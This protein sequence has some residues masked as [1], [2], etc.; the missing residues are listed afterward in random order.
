MVPV[1]GAIVSSPDTKVITEL[2]K[3]YPGRASISPILDLFITLLSMGENGL[4]ELWKERQ[5]LFI[6]LKEKLQVFAD[7][8][9]E[10][11]LISPANS[12]S[13]G[14]TLETLGRPK[15]GQKRKEIIEN[16]NSEQSSELQLNDWKIEERIIDIDGVGD[17]TSRKEKDVLPLLSITP[18]T[19]Q[20]EN[21]PDIAIGLDND[22]NTVN[23]AEHSAISSSVR[24]EDSVEIKGTSA[25]CEKVMCVLEDDVSPRKK[26]L[27]GTID[28]SSSSRGGNDTVDG[29]I[30]S[31]NFK[32]MESV[33]F[34]GSMLFQRNVSGCRV[35]QQSDSSTFING[36]EFVSWGAHTSHYPVSYFTAACSVGVT[37]SEINLFLE[38]LS[39]VWKQY[40]K[41]KA[42]ICEANKRSS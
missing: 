13:I 9:G 29:K 5:K 15:E 22:Q 20:L 12:I 21:S 1:G 31:E 14:M 8:H 7:S 38:R 36:V 42:K 40:D 10:K 4:L 28:G 35:V 30:S 23:V 2:G 16:T 26:V 6:S 19:S 32:T 18:D 34:L 37:E 25:G 17:V 41:D 11:I 39:K 27:T 24:K 3:L 33:S